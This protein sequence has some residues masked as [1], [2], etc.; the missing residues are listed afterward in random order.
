[1]GFKKTFN[2]V[3]LNKT[4]EGIEPELSDIYQ[5]IKPQSETSVKPIQPTSEMKRGAIN[6]LLNEDIIMSALDRFE[7]K[8]TMLKK[9]REKS[10]IVLP[11]G[12]SAYP[13]DGFNYIF[14]VGYKLF[15]IEESLNSYLLHPASLMSKRFKRK[16]EKIPKNKRKELKRLKLYLRKAA[17]QCKLKNYHKQSR[18]IVA[19]CRAFFKKRQTVLMYGPGRL[20]DRQSLFMINGEFYIVL[21]QPDLFR[22]CKIY[23]RSTD[24]L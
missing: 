13:I 16:A 7:R 24:K 22:K 8:H 1:M 15:S 4:N 2:Q 20:Y 5:K 6:H 10:K 11:N 21:Y 19:E 3:N 14:E 12:K 23:E 18:Q 17:K 9:D